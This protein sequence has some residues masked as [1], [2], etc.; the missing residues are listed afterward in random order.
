MREKIWAGGTFNAAE[1]LEV[2]T[3]EGLL[4]KLE[5]YVKDSRVGWVKGFFNESLTPL[6][7]SERQMRPALYVEIDCDLYSSSVDALTWLFEQGLIVEGTV[8]NVQGEQYHEDCFLCEECEAPLQS[9]FMVNN[10]LNYCVDCHTDLFSDKCAGCG[11][12]CT[13]G[14]LLALE[15][16][17]V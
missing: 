16:G 13:S 11:F 8:L 9:G 14:S 7:A 2:R 4:A 17:V 12:P 5:G 10:S 6:L 1:T 15:K 3:Y